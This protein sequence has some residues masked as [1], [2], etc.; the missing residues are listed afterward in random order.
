MKETVEIMP[1]NYNKEIHDL[2]QVNV[3][4]STDKRTIYYMV[5]FKKNALTKEV[6][7]DIIE[8]FIDE[9]T[10]INNINAPLNS[11]QL[12]ICSNNFYKLTK[13]QFNKIIN[14]NWTI[15]KVG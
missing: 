6:S 13:E 7:E 12:L 14:K 8:K 4:E 1:T 15:I 3:E 9:L 2:Y 11:S 5:L 10:D